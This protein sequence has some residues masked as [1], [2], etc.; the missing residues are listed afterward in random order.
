MIACNCGF[1]LF[2]L[3]YLLWNNVGFCCCCFWHCL[4]LTVAS[5]R[6]W[7]L[8]DGYYCFLLPSFNI[9][10][11]HWRQWLRFMLCGSVTFLPF[12]TQLLLFLLLWFVFP[13]ECMFILARP[14]PAVTNFCAPPHQIIHSHIASPIPTHMWVN[15]LFSWINWRFSCFRWWFFPPIYAHPRPSWPTTPLFPVIPGQWTHT[16][17]SVIISDHPWPSLTLHSSPFQCH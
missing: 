15:K 12:G 5:C 9:M 1:C 6:L 10:K 16:K 13:S 7:A 2:V 8:L 17:P 14:C 3:C 4:A 11:V